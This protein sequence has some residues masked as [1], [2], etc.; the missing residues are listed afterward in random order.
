MYHAEAATK[1]KAG[2]LLIN[3]AMK[4]GKC[5]QLLNED[6]IFRCLQNP[7]LVHLLLTSLQSPVFPAAFWIFPLGYFCYCFKLSICKTK[8]M[9]LLLELML[10]LIFFSL[11]FLFLFFSF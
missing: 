10:P 11:F 2:S 5:F 9:T 3:A 8:F 7:K 6:D 1:F 4:E